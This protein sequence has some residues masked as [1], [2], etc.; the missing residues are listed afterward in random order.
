MGE[1]VTHLTNHTH[2]H[3][4]PNQHVPQA[5]TTSLSSPPVRNH[6]RMFIEQA[7]TRARARART[8]IFFFIKTKEERLKTKRNGM[9]IFIY[10]CSHGTILFHYTNLQEKYSHENKDVPH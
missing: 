3:T 4:H 1:H 5:R 7:N 10:Y 8:R 6:Q 9:P 2:A